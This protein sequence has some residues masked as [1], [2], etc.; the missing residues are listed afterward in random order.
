M[1][2]KTTNPRF[3]R[4]KELPQIQ[5]SRMIK[6]RGNHL[7]FTVAKVREVYQAILFCV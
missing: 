3:I 5:P 4:M 6:N 2:V 7:N 1:G